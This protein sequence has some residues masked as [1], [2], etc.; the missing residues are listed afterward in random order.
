MRG[1]VREREVG[2]GPGFVEEY[3]QGSEEGIGKDE[4]RMSR[5]KFG[6]AAPREE[7]GKKPWKSSGRFE[8]MKKSNIIQFIPMEAQKKK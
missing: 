3:L 2:S 8:V 6:G 4:S 5:E 1:V 7:N